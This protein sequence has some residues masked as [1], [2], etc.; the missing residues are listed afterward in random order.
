MNPYPL[1]WINEVQPNNTEH[2]A[3]QHRHNS[4]WI[5]LYNSGTNPIDLGGVLALEELHQSDAWAFP[6]G[7]TSPGQFGDLRR[8]PA[9]ISTTT[10]LH[11]SFRFDPPTAPSCFPG[12]ADPRLHQLSDMEA[13]YQ[14]VN[15]GRTTVHPADFLLPTPGASN[16]PSPAP[17]VI[18][19][20]MASNTGTLT[21]P[22]TGTFEDWFELY[23]FGSAPVNLSGFYL[24]DSLNIRNMWRIPD[25][26]IIPPHDFLF[27]W[28]DSDF[29]GPIGSVTRFIPISN[30]RDREAK[31]GS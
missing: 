19:E 18:N 25:G 4:P 2:I 3:G 6:A 31:L 15:A 7:M 30:C 17:I 28:A 16:N 26:T 11:T 14:R 1:L 20:W 13:G 10:V 21:N 5:E 9:A 8:W 22:F 23:N 24:T 27:C 12:T 29:R